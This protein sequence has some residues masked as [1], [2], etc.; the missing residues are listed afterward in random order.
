M[1]I[2]YKFKE[3]HVVDHNPKTGK[4][5]IQRGFC[6]REINTKEKLKILYV[7]INTG[8]NTG[9]IKFVPENRFYPFAIIKN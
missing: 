9:Q 8:P 7:K 1:E 2:I 3:G 4:M 6:T 5:S